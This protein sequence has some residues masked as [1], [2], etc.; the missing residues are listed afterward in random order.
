MNCLICRH[1]IKHQ[2]KCEVQYKGRLKDPCLYFE[3]KDGWQEEKQ[4][5]T[6]ASIKAKRKGVM[7]SCMVTNA[8]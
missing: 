1:F 4:A 6:L 2:F 3:E 8:G 5:I 7:K